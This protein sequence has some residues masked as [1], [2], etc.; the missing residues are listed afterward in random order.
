M[1]T[2]IDESLEIAAEKFKAFGFSQVQIEQLLSSAKRDLEAEVGKL[3]ELLRADSPDTAMI[4]QSLHALKGLL[5]NMGHTEAGDKMAELRNDA[6][7]EDQI[8]KIRET[9]HL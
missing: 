8:V 2:F 5:Y 1:G 6:G 4:N 9:L 7:R 3:E